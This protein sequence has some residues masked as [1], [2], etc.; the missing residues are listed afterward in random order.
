MKNISLTKTSQKRHHE[1]NPP[2]HLLV[3]DL[4]L[5]ADPKVAICQFCIHP[6]MK[7]ADGT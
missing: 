3:V 4:W 5:S 2:P 1:A 7:G 6:Q